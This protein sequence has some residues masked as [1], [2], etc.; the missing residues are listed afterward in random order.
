MTTAETR[1]LSPSRA[2]AGAAA[3]A[4]EIARAE[5]PR[6]L[7]TALLGGAAGALVGLLIGHLLLALVL[8]L[9]AATAAGLW[10]RGRGAAARWRMGAAGERRTGR[11]LN[12]LQRRGWVMLH[13]RAMNRTFANV[14]HLAIAPDGTVWNID[15]KVRRGAL[16][17]DA[18]RNY[19]RIGKTSGYQLVSSTLYE[20]DLIAK[21]LRVLVGPVQV[22]SVLAVHRARFPAWRRIE[23]KG[24]R[25]M[26]ARK[27]PGW[28]AS[29]AGAASSDQSRIAA[30]AEELFP[31]YV[32]R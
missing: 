7:L 24:V 28:L 1:T 32:Q 15:S 26:S 13:D 25:I 27:V 12:R 30:A 23:I 10:Q 8:T 21:Q 5:R 22:R 20:S 18:R 6:I 17:Y 31:P 29:Q 4:A 3:K 16:R 11:A 9:T 2:G 14:D 19:L